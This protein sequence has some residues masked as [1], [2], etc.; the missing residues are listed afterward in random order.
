MLDIVVVGSLNEDLTVRVPRLP[1]PGETVLGH[2][3]FRDT[4]GKGANQAVAAARLGR[5][6]AM[7][8]MVGSDPAGSKLIDALQGA[9]VE[10]TA[11]GRSDAAGTGMAVITVDGSGENTIVV[12]PGANAMLSPGD[13]EAAAGL[14][15]EAAVTLL[16]LEVGTDVVERA[17]ELSG[18]RVVLNPAPAQTL[19]EEL[20]GSVDVLVPNQT[21][22]A[23]LADGPIPERSG[24]AI[25]LA[26]RLDGPG[27][28]VVTL[29]A[30]GAL[31]VADGRSSL[32]PAPEVDAVDPTGAGDAFC[33]GLADGLVRGLDLDG[34][35]EWAVRCGAAAVTRW[36]AQ[37][38]LPTRA[39]VEALR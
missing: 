22:L 19:S 33:A 15:T 13:L 16:Q 17:I 12:S 5:R 35:V 2:D 21:E 23:L 34:A 4:G 8:G 10:A 25:R 26:G 6:V 24:D 36:G 31:V 39:E 11:V 27:A 20:L 18:G 29:G 30:G 37:G 1:A 7:V 14:L 28:V 9:G 3:H 32:I 38:S